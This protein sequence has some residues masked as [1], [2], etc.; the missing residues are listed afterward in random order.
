MVEIQLTS[1]NKVSHGV[2]IVSDM[3]YLSIWA[4]LL[5]NSINPIGGSMKEDE[6]SIKEL[7]EEG[8]IHNSTKGKIKIFPIGI[9]KDFY[10][11]KL[12]KKD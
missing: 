5:L 12:D 10:K 4:F 2:Y 6:G 7:S 11:E 3:P 9:L 1:N 8:L